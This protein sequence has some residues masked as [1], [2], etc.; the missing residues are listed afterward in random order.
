MEG[1]AMPEVEAEFKSLG[2]FWNPKYRDR[3]IL[4]AF[5]VL[6]VKII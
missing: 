1:I 5:R 2:V 6:L 3:S 4:V